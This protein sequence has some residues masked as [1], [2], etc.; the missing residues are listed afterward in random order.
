[1][2][3]IFGHDEYPLRRVLHSVKE[4]RIDLRVETWIFVQYGSNHECPEE[5][6]GCLAPHIGPE[7]LGISVPSL[8]VAS[9]RINRLAEGR[10]EHRPGNSV[11][12][13]TVVDEQ[14]EFLTRRKPFRAVCDVGKNDGPLL[15]QIVQDH[16]FRWHPS[17]RRRSLT[18]RRKRGR[19]GAGL[20][21]RLRCILREY[22]SRRSERNRGENNERA[23]LRLE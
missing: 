1:M 17:I 19:R 9:R 15:Q 10:T 21:L 8:F 12:G 23:N 18:G 14:L 16:W 11:H 20:R 3:I 22:L 2:T 13:N 7:S 6:A 5:F 4:T